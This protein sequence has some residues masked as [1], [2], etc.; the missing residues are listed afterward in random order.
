MGKT[1]TIIIELIFLALLMLIFFISFQYLVSFDEYIPPKQ[2]TY[3]LKLDS[4]ASTNLESAKIYHN[5]ETNY[6]IITFSFSE[7]DY[8]GSPSIIVN[9]PAVPKKIK[10][11]KN[12]EE[13]GFE[14]KNSSLTIKLDKPIEQ[15]DYIISY[16]VE[17]FPSGTFIFSNPKTKID[18]GKI[19]FELGNDYKCEGICIPVKSKIE[20]DKYNSFKEIKLKMEESNL[21]YF[22][23]MGIRDL[24]NEQGLAIG[25]AASSLMSAIM[26][27]KNLLEYFYK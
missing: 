27:F 7:K 14:I 13:I 20:T 4:S 2:Y 15:D 10:V 21:H 17:L 23:L 19:E 6:G 25:I 16:Y 3:E 22:E 11:I 8:L 1:R 5:F 9:L 26:I 12:G 18:S 24:R